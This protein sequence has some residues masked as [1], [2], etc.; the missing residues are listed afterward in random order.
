MLIALLGVERFVVRQEMMLNTA[1]SAAAGRAHFAARQ[2]AT[3]CEILCLGDSL[4]KFGVI[5][6]VIE[7]RLGRPAYN[8]ALVGGQPPGAFFTL[9]RALRA[10]ARPAAVV[11]DFKANI[12]ATSPSYNKRQWAEMLTISECVKLGIELRDS[13][14]C[15]G[16]V[17]SKLLPSYKMRLEIRPLVV[18]ALAGKAS[19]SAYAA[20][21]YV[22]NINRNQGAI[23]M[24]EEYHV[25][26]P[27]QE[28]LDQVY[29]PAKWEID[30]VNARYMR[31][32]L[33][34]TA[35]ARIPVFWVL[36]PIRAHLQAERDS[37]GFDNLYLRRAFGLYKQF[38]NLTLV[39][40][41]HAGFPDSAF[42]DL[43]HLNRSGAQALSAALADVIG[44]AL[45]QRN[46]ACLRVIELPRY[47]AFNLDPLPEDLDSSRVAL[48]LGPLPRLK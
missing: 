6:R 31:R 41:R 20:A 30:P 24:N 38:P 44:S 28:L 25:P 7:G 4:M 2:E 32:L 22:R 43:A 33:E 5:P 37:K 12:I 3:K 21:A 9:R 10:G 18:A 47:R 8:L 13:S 17:L 15:A 27:G 23:V 29:F 40:A 46:S 34:L 48:K 26:M 16:L 35:A 1:E 42:F 19:P 45:A 14:Y 39:D 11:V 36:P